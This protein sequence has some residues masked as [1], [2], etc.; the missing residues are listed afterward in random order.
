M[1]GK[2]WILSAWLSRINIVHLKKVRFGGLF[3]WVK[4]GNITR[5]H[6]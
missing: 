6:Y 2:D 3:L 4:Y 1:D 5:T